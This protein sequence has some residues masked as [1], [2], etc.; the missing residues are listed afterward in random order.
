MMKDTKEVKPKP[1]EKKEVKPENKPEEKKENKDD[2]INKL[3]EDDL[4][5]I[6][7]KKGDY[8]VHVKIIV[9][10]II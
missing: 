1:E 7:L 2:L 5:V 10:N 9:L 3:K 6:Q 4:T 8:Q